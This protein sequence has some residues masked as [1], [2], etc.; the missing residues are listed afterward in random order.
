M[1]DNQCEG[2]HFLHAPISP[3]CGTSKNK[4]LIKKNRDSDQ[5]PTS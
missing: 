1:D 4:L 2:W 3:F 5:L